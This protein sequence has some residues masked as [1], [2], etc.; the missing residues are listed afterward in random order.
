M[1][2]TAEAAVVATR[3]EQPESAEAAVSLA[4]SPSTQDLVYLI[5]I[6]VRN[7]FAKRFADAHLLFFR[8][9]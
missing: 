5:S 6:L 4:S 3:P 2:P 8:Y 9:K 7:S 1:Q